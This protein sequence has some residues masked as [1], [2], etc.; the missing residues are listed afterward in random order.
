MK[1]YVVVYTE[2]FESD[3]IDNEVLLYENR[4]EAVQELENNY[5]KIK[6]SYNEDDVEWD[7]FEND[8][9]SFCAKNEYDEFERY[10]GK[11]IERIYITKKEVD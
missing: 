7:N 6:E 4:E 3:G 10:E 11:I 1:L 5:D 8:S 9:Y 2:Y